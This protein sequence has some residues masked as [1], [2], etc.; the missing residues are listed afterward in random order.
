MFEA[1]H[2]GT[3]YFSPTGLQMKAM[4]ARSRASAE[5]YNPF[6]AMVLFVNDALLS[7]TTRGNVY[8]STIFSAR[9]ECTQCTT[10]CARYL[11][12]ASQCTGRFVIADSLVDPAV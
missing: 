11:F 5:C 4:K 9:K 2:G 1:T 3:D 6:L 12:S 8:I 10:N 7:Y